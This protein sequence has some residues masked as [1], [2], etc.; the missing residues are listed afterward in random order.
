[1][2]YV[3]I[4]DDTFIGGEPASKGK[5]YEVDEATLKQLVRCKRAVAC[6]PPK[7]STPKAKAKEVES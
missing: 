3:E 2:F 7:N 1:M 6:D 5:K 4:T